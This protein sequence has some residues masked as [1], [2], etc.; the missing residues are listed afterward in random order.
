MSEAPKQI[1]F[2]Y[3]N[4]PFFRALHVDG[5]IGGITPRGYIHVAVFS[6]RAEIPYSAVHDI[7]PE[8]RLSETPINAEGPQG[9]VREIDADLIFSKQVATE[10]RDWLTKHIDQLDALEKLAVS[11]ASE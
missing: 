5:A 4:S 2:R 7:S 1:T 10:L 6:E 11:Q 9:V 3:V 8:G